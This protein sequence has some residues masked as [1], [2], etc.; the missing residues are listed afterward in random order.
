[1]GYSLREAAGRAGLSMRE[2]NERMGE[3]RDTITAMSEAP[4]ARVR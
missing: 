3:L 1:M 4:A 2:A